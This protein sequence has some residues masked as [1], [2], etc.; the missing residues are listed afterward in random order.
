ME[1][2]KWSKAY[3]KPERVQLVE[4]A[5]RAAERKTAGEIV[6]MIVRRSSAV[7]HVPFLLLSLLVSV[8][9][10]VDGPGWQY[11]HLGEH[12][13]WYLLDTVALLALALALARRPLLQRLLT[14]RQD[15]VDQVQMRAQVEFYQSRIQ[16]TRAATGVLLF[17]SLL[18]RQAVVL[19]DKAIAERVPAQTWE[20]VCDLMI[21]GIKEGHIGL[22]L[23]A[24]VERC[25][26]ILAAQFPVQADDTNELRDVLVIKE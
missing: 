10:I 1:L 26:D 20:E 6:P 22:G 19:A 24:A 11:Q 9:L 13:A 12:W 8:F 25:G 17:A 14:P 16:S 5:V 4:D 7:G 18:E 21:R 2:P 3:L 15:Q 23:A